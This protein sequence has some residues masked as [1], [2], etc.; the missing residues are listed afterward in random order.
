MR[1]TELNLLQH[2]LERTTLTHMQPYTGEHSSTTEADQQDHKDYQD[3]ELDQT[4]L[5]LQL[6]GDQWKHFPAELQWMTY[7]KEWHI[8]G[9]KISQLPDYLA[10]FTQLAILEIPKNAITELPPEI[11]DNSV[12]SFPSFINTWGKLSLCIAAFSMSVFSVIQWSTSNHSSPP[13]GKLTELRELNVSYNRLC[14]IPPE[15]GNCENMERLELT[16]NFLSE[17]PFELRNLTQVVHLDLAENSFMSIPIC[18]LRMSSLQLLDLSNNQLTDLPQDMD[19]LDQ[20]VTLFVHKNKLMYLPQALTNISTLKMIVVSAEDL[21]CI[22]TRLCS[23]PDIKFIRLYD[24][25]FTKTCEETKKKEKTKRK[26]WREQRE[27]KVKDSGDKEFIEA[28]I[29]SL[30]DRDTVPFST[31]KV[32]IA[33]LL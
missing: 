22:P 21:T 20:L 24:N 10:L 2:Y 26:R 27:E 15:L 12:D 28:Y 11:G 16:G 5:I 3:Q 30:Q 1:T 29:G 18:T 19:R 8:R 7:L 32:S 17:L 31:T 14:K 13:S 33:C 25:M 6:E 23:N 4:K 9:T